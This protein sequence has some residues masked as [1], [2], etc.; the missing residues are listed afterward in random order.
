MT[1]ALD[2]LARVMLLTLYNNVKMFFNQVFKLKITWCQ[3][4]FSEPISTIEKYH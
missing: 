4:I 1:A 2:C 3:N